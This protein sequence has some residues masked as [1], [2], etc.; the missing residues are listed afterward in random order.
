MTVHEKTPVSIVSVDVPVSEIQGAHVLP[1]LFGKS[2]MA[3]RR[4]HA[5]AKSGTATPSPGRRKGRRLARS[6]GKQA[7]VWR[8]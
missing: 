2:Q 8:K 4:H 7:H 1:V 6:T 5:P 3:E